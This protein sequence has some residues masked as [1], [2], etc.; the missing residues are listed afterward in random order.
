MKLRQPAFLVV[1]IVPA[2]AANNS[3]RHRRTLSATAKKPASVA[4]FLY[5]SLSMTRLATLLLPTARLSHSS[6]AL[7]LIIQTPSSR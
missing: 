6:R 7:K 1:T 5:L 3:R 2:T 4:G